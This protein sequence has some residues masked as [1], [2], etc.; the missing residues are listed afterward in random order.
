MRAWFWRWWNDRT[1]GPLSH[2]YRRDER[3]D[4][5]M[6]RLGLLQKVAE[7]ELRAR[8]DRS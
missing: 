5:I 6:E 8:S 1:P 3:I 7:K 2:A 4:R